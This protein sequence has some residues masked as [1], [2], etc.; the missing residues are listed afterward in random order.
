MIWH[1]AAPRTSN[2]PQCEK[3]DSETAPPVAETEWRTTWYAFFVTMPWLNAA[4]M[5]ISTAIE[6]NRAFTSAMLRQAS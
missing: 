4:S 5:L 3:I 6:M 2:A 1:H